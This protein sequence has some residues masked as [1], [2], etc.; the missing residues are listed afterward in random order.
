LISTNPSG[1]A[2]T[3]Y[4]LTCGT[5]VQ[6][7]VYF[8]GAGSTVD[9]WPAFWTSSQDWPATGEADIAEGLGTL[10]S[11][12]HDDA[13]TDNSGTVSGTWAGDSHTYTLD[14][15]PGENTVYWDGQLIRSYPTDDGCAP[16]YLVFNV[17]DG[18]GPTVTGAA[19]AV[20]VA[21]V[22]VWNAA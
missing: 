21:Y 12:Y 15:E 6:A 19:G 1:G 16:Q 22:A 7:S 10:T 14:R 5:V 17:G 3:G 9:N 11:N 2:P 13:G 4:T 20:K 8:P 18:Q